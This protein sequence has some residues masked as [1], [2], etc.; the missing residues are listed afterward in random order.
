MI[1]NFLMKPTKFKPGM[2]IDGWFLSEKVPG[3]HIFWDGLTR[4]QKLEN[5]PFANESILIESTGVW[6]SFAQA[7][8]LP[9]SFLNKLPCIPL[10]GYLLS[11]PYRFV[12][13]SS[14][15]FDLIFENEDFLSLKKGTTFEEELL[16]LNEMVLSDD[17]IF[18]QKQT[19]I[20]NEF[21]TSGFL[22]SPKSVW[23]SQE[24][25]DFLEI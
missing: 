20:I 2:N 25:M 10:E 11:Y 5:I 9:D 21:P 19:K 12:I 22:R 7:F 6:D 4:G 8:L 1:N 23:T 17:Q 18:V 16:F 3:T 13:Y 15:P 24:S 14:P